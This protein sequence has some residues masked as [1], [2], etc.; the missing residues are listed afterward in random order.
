MH[1]KPGP[2]RGEHQQ[3][4][5][6]C[7][8][9]SGLFIPQGAVCSV[10]DPSHT[11]SIFSLLF[12]S[13]PLLKPKILQNSQ[14][15]DEDS[16]SNR[17]WLLVVAVC[18]CVYSQVSRLSLSMCDPER[19]GSMSIRRSELRPSG[20]Q[21]ISSSPS[22]IGST[23]IDSCKVIEEGSPESPEEVREEES[24]FRFFYLFFIYLFLTFY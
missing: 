21:G 9:E 22:D 20:M 15:C 24:L 1:V 11:S 3:L 17:I 14:S 4:T 13:V 7:S 10:R 2:K 8:G 5:T 23:G 12:C 16:M 19:T 18:G 6:F